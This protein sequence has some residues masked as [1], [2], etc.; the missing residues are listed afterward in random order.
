MIDLGETHVLK[1]HV[2]QPGNGFVGRDRA[3][4]D[5]LQQLSERCGVHFFCNPERSEGTLL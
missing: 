2:A 1:R 5:I 4:A 3:F